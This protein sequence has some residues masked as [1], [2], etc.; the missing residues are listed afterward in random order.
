MN[1]LCGWCLMCLFQRLKNEDFGVGSVVGIDC[2]S[3]LWSA[4][5]FCWFWELGVCW[6][7]FSKYFLKI[8]GIF[9]W[10]IS[11]D[12][13]LVLAVFPLASRCRCFNFRAWIIGGGGYRMIQI[14]KLSILQ[15]TWKV[16]KLISWMRF[17]Y[18]FVNSWGLHGKM[19][20]SIL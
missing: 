11:L 1:G 3:H 17:F 7:S 15:F 18:I 9:I 6:A 20:L 4:L 10:V 16:I 2:Y 19:C 14:L 13:L 8:W 5:V 12:F